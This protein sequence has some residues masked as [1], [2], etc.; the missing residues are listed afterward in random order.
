MFTEC[1]NGLQYLEPRAKWKTQLTEMIFREVG[2]DALVY[3]VLAEYRLILFEAK[4][5][6]PPCH[7]HGGAP[8]QGCRISSCSWERISRTLWG[9]GDLVLRHKI[10]SI[11]GLRDWVEAG[12]LLSYGV[13]FL[14][15]IRRAAEYVDTIVKGAKASDLPVEQPTKFELVVNLKTAKAI[16]VEVPLSVLQLADEVIELTFFTAARDV[17][18]GPSRHIAMLSLTVAFGAK[19]TLACRPPERIY[20]FTPFC[21]GPM[22]SSP[23]V[24][25]TPRASCLSHS[26]QSGLASTVGLA[27]VDGYGCF[28][29]PQN[30]RGT[31][32]APQAKLFWGV[33]R[34][35]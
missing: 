5:P 4:A 9:I 13:N 25:V 23:L 32:C 29:N 7:V 34:A 27:I 35:R 20:E 18:I 16:G 15:I 26:F 30:L 33:P 31:P 28:R 22:R 11:S 10:A 3:L 17:A 1:G 2:Q 21:N 8:T 6:Q 12:G 14:T 19:R 24:I